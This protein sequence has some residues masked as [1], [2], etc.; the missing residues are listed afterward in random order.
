MSR[1]G[2]SAILAGLLLASIYIP[3]SASSA[4]V[5][6]DLGDDLQRAAERAWAGD[7]IVVVGTCTGEFRLNV[8]ITLRGADDTATLR[9]PARGTVLRLSAPEGSTSRIRVQDIRVE[10]GDIGISIAESTA[11]ALDG[12]RIVGNTTGLS[13][14]PFADVVIRDSDVR[15]NA[16]DGIANDHGRLELGAS[17]VQDNA[18]HGIR[19]REQALTLV[20]DSRIERNGQ[21]GIA[22]LNSSTILD[23]SVVIMNA[24]GGVHNDGRSY[25]EIDDSEITGNVSREAGGGVYLGAPVDEIDGGVTI[26]DSRIDQNIAGTR[27]GGIYV[28]DGIS[29]IELADVTF[30]GNVP[31]DCHGC[32]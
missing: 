28:E 9:G 32:P 3:A 18:G 4:R 22:N 30:M 14:E 10:G 7:E 20:S 15:A 19:N 26:R 16:G 23:G 13:L 24:G 21:V 27:G 12:V 8:G 6:C 2:W 17:V 11:A 25:L 1:P 5:L 31:D 29:S